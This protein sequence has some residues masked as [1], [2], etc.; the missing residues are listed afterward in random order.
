MVIDSEGS[1]QLLPDTRHLSKMEI[2][3]KKQNRSSLIMPL[4]H[5]TGKNMWI[6]KPTGFN[7]GKG[8]HVC[9][10]FGKVKKLIKDYYKGR[11]PT[12]IV[13]PVEITPILRTTMLAD[14]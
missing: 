11:E 1:F 2:N 4:S 7:R 10:T 12:A 14:T 3:S 9:G 13:Q 5:F 6:L 8:I